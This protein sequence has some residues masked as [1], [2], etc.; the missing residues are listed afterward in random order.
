MFSR[1]MVAA[2][3][4]DRKAGELRCCHWVNHMRLF[5]VAQKMS[6]LRETSTDNASWHLFN[7]DT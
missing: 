4:P 6:G 5:G 1:K 3:V 7:M 2:M